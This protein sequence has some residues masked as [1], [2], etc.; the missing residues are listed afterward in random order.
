LVLMLLDL[1]KFKAI[2]DTYGHPAGDAVLRAFAARLG[3]CVRDVDAV[4]RLGGDEFAV[5]VEDAASPDAAE[6]IAKKLIAAMEAPVEAEGHALKVATSIGIAYTTQVASARALTALA[7]KAL[8]DAKAGGR[9]TWRL[10][11]D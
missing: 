9:N 2:N 11:V 8:Y 4:A 5:L 1:D 10:I 7:D 3:S 6:A